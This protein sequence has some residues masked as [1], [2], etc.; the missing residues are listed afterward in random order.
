MFKT[1]LYKNLKQIVKT[2]YKNFYSSKENKNS[3]LIPVNIL[4]SDSETNFKSKSGEHSIT[5]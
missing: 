4:I 5:K 2:W 3:N 1:Y